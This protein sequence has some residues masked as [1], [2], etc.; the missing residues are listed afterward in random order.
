MKSVRVPTWA[1]QTKSL[2]FPRSSANFLS[3]DLLSCPGA[4]KN[5]TLKLKEQ[6]QITSALHYRILP[7]SQS[8]RIN[9]HSARKVNAFCKQA[10]KRKC[11]P[12]L[13]DLSSTHV[14]NVRLAQPITSP[15]RQWTEFSK[16][17]GLSASVSFLP[18]PY[19]HRS[20]FSSRPIFRAD[21]IPKTPFLGLSLLPN[22]METL[23]MQANKLFLHV[24]EPRTEQDSNVLKPIYYGY[25]LYM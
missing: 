20:F 16:S 23:A 25:E 2:G 12:L 1:S 4:F 24:L 18:L 8:S 15:V 22:P 6:L 21:K 11:L 7:Y 9:T 14:K 17:R 5:V 10:S 13:W 3:R 19:P